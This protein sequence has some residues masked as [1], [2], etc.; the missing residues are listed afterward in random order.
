MTLQS[1]RA[2]THHSHR[3][4]AVFQSGP[5][6]HVCRLLAGL[7]T[8]ASARR[9]P[10][11][12][13]FWSFMPGKRNLPMMDRLM[14]NVVRIPWSGCWIFMGATNDFGYGI[15][16]KDGGRGAGNERAHRA[17]YEAF[18]GHVPD[19]LF[20]CHHCDV[21]ACCNPDHLFIGTNADNMADC[22]S[23]GRNSQPPRNLH[24]VGGVHPLAKLTTDNV[25]EIRRLA[26]SGVMQKDLAAQ[27]GVSQTS[28]SKII[29]GKRWRHVA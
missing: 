2:V 9:A 6:G 14:A 26:A 11:G 13:C 10:W 20:V 25:V 3:L 1:E 5:M 12:F 16:G 15:I 29:S 18:I 4:A 7:P 27:Y 24:V 22:K 23:K 8:R 19:G 21:P 28:M 17:T